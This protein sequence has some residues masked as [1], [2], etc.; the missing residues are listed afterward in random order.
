MYFRYNATVLA[1][2]QTGSGKTYTMGTGFEVAASS[3]ET[4]GIVP[5]AV[6]Q[7]FEGINKRQNEARESGIPPPEFKVSAQFLELYNED[8]LDLFDNATC[9]VNKSSNG[10]IGG[11]GKRSTSASSGQ[12]GIRIHEDANGNIYTVSL[13][14]MRWILNWDF[15]DTGKH[16]ALPRNSETLQQNCKLF[17]QQFGDVYEACKSIILNTCFMMSKPKYR[18]FLALL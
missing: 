16:D 13:T 18:I 12:S 17:L 9:S 2:G 10:P 3:E 6:K 8:I 15:D 7:L 1:Y 5:R 4:I 14:L 11:L